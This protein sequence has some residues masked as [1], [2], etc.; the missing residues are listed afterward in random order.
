MK[1]VGEPPA[2]AS[3]QPADRRLKM[4]LRLFTVGAYTYRLITLRP[5]TR[6]AFSTN[7]AGEPGLKADHHTTTR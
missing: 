1:I 4:H 5:G 6:V 2:P 7:F 3:A